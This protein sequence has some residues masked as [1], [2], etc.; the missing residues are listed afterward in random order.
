MEW[1]QSPLSSS[2]LW[3]ITAQQEESGR[4]RAVRS[5][6]LKTKNIP[7]AAW[8]RIRSSWKIRPAGHK[9]DPYRESRRVSSSSQPQCLFATVI[10]RAALLKTPIK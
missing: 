6:K 7:V 1:K 2:Q 5:V 9:L 3:Q 4:G 10:D 8:N